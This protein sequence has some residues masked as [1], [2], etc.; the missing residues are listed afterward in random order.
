MGLWAQAET[1]NS[2][3]LAYLNAENLSYVAKLIL[4]EVGCVVTTAE[5]G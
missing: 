1:R 3:V 5:N 4:E 2:E